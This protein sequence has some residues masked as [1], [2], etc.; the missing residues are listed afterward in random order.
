M[1]RSRFDYN[2]QPDPDDENTYRW[3]GFRWVLVDEEEDDE[4]SDAFDEW[5]ER[6]QEKLAES[7]EY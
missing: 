4:D 6:R 5:E 1:K 3:N 2:W 7:L